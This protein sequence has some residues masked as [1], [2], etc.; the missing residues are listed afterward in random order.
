[1][2]SFMEVG[3][4]DKMAEHQSRVLACASDNGAD[5]YNKAVVMVL[6]FLL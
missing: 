6:I 2:L 5:N 4:A 1:M 3:G